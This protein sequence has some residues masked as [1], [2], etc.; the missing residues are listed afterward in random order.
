M[1]FLMV[2]V[3]LLAAIEIAA[4]D[5]K[6]SSTNSSK[7][8]TSTTST[9]PLEIND[10]SFGAGNSITSAG[11]ITGRSAPSPV[12]NAGKSGSKH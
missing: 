2:V 9:K 4:A 1:R 10:W 7:S 11:R 8:T 3:M 12:G 5:D 6:K